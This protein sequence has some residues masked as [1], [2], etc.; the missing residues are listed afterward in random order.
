MEHTKCKNNSI[1][2]KKLTEGQDTIILKISSSENYMRSL[3]I[4]RRQSKTNI[5]KNI[6]K[7]F[8]VMMI[9][10]IVYLLCLDSWH[11]PFFKIC[12]A[13]FVLTN[14]LVTPIHLSCTGLFIFRFSKDCLYSHWFH[15]VLPLINRES[16]TD[17][18]KV[19]FPVAS[20]KR[21]MPLFPRQL[22]RVM[23]VALKLRDISYIKITYW[24]KSREF[25]SIVLILLNLP[26]C[27][28]SV[29]LKCGC[30]LQSLVKLITYNKM[31]QWGLSVLH[32]SVWFNCSRLDIW[33][34][35]CVSNIEP[36]LSMFILDVVQWQTMQMMALLTGNLHSGVNR[37]NYHKQMGKMNSYS[38]KFNREDRNRRKA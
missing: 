16:A 3:L 25:W 17:L 28:K 2:P 37:E 33:T 20:S 11:L 34:S 26:L 10:D 5:F 31:E 18:L 29:F 27:P 6:F 7:R 12:M 23:A 21:M 14:S 1:Q 19:A 9:L 24:A 36:D 8:H 4:E 30:K 32:Q 22:L 38:A 13:W 35:I 15:N